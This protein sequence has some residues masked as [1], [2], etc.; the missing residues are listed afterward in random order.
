MFTIEPPPWRSM[1]GVTNLAILTTLRRS[2]SIPWCQSSSEIV[3]Q[4]PFGGMA[5][6][7]DD[8][9]D[10]AVGADRRIDQ[11]GQDRRDR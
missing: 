7:V 2:R 6:V 9:V 10:P 11:I 3:E 4:V 8:G 1:I 5:G